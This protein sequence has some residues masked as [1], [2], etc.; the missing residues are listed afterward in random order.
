MSQA[1]SRSAFQGAQAE[2]DKKGWQQGDCQECQECVAR[3][4]AVESVSSSVE[5]IVE[6]RNMATL[7]VVMSQS[8]TTVLI[9]SIAYVLDRY[10]GRFVFSFSK[11]TEF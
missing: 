9:E 4:G 7:L 2:Q 10:M 3:P 11:M 8:F 6:G 5:P 1:W